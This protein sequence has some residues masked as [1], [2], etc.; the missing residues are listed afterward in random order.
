MSSCTYVT[1]QTNL[2]VIKTLHHTTA[3]QAPAEFFNHFVTVIVLGVIIPI[4]YRR[5]KSFVLGRDHMQHRSAK[6]K[7][8][9]VFCKLF[10]NF[11]HN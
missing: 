1:S 4:I 3:P 8:P 6:G 9:I 10:C 5:R 7:G 2:T 11:G